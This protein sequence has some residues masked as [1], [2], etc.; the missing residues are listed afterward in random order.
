VPQ[1]AAPER[2]SQASRGLPGPSLDGL[3]LATGG[4]LDLAR[5]GL[6]GHRDGHCQHAVLV[7]GLD[8]L[9][10]EALAKEE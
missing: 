9:R 2:R 4:D 8:V 3:G 1:S 6:F 5:L 7:V 10:V